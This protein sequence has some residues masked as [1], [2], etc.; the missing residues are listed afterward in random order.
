MRVLGSKPSRLTES[1]EVAPQGAA[2]FCTKP[3]KQGVEELLGDAAGAGLFLR[4]NF[5]SRSD[6]SQDEGIRHAIIRGISGGKKI[7]NGNAQPMSY[8][9]TVSANGGPGGPLQPGRGCEF[10]REP[11]WGACAEGT[12]ILD[13]NRCWRRRLPVF[14]DLPGWQVDQEHRKCRDGCERAST[15]RS[16]AQTVARSEIGEQPGSQIMFYPSMETGR[17]GVARRKREK[18]PIWKFGCL[19]A[20]ARGTKISASA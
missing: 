10:G 16:T 3:C 17:P 1:K 2:F 15:R 6:T 19:I 5:V 7:K 12:A 11:R 20:S 4:T 18:S 9:E 13:R 8:S 14:P